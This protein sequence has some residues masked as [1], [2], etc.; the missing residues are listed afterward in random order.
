MKLTA[1]QLGRLLFKA[2]NEPRRNQK[3]Y[4]KDLGGDGSAD[5]LDQVLEQAQSSKK[6]ADEFERLQK[7]RDVVRESVSSDVDKSVAGMLADLRI[8]MEQE[9]MTQK[10]LADRCGFS[11]PQVAAYLSGKKEPGIG[12][13]AKL[14]SALNRTWK[15][16]RSSEWPMVVK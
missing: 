13:L 2:A 14:A 16:G 5:E 7:Q 8:A 10:E 12:N 4:L 11:Q 6:A 9:A 3:R 15:L 1:V